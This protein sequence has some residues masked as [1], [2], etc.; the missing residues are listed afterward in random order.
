MDCKRS[1]CRRSS[2][3]IVGNDDLLMEIILRLPAKPL[4]RFKS[5][6]KHWHYLISAAF[7]SDR[8]TRLH[9]NRR[10]PQPSFIF[11]SVSRQF[12]YFNPNSKIFV[13][14]RFNYPYVRILQ[15]SHGL[16]LLECRNK[17]YGRKDYCVYNPVTRQ[18]R[19]LLIDSGDKTQPAKISALFLDFDPSKSL[20]YR[21]A[22]LRIIYNPLPEYSLDVYNSESHTWKR[23]LVPFTSH[24]NVTYWKGIYCN[25][26]VYW[27]RPGFISYYMDLQKGF[28]GTA[29]VIR[30]PSRKFLEVNKNYLMESNGHLHC[31][32]IYMRPQKKSLLV[33]ELLE[34]NSGW[35][36][37]YRVNLN[38]VSDA[39]PEMNSR[40]S[41]L[42]IVR[43]DRE[44]DSSVL[45]HVPG[46]VIL[47]WFF[48]ASFEVV[49][50]S[51]TDKIFRDCQFRF[52]RND[53]AYHFIE[54]LA[55]V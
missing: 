9:S 46:K 15:S 51:N 54:S 20:H 12:F 8:H 4:I 38:P 33:F 32:S 5:V 42:R 41:V 18:S 22:F 26:R 47:Y 19:K 55:S 14:F 29:P 39:L 53:D 49:L 34:D 13:P 27:I 11:H 37:R 48:Y 50:D 45:L 17:K 24:I 43:G 16:M 10:K 44:E 35:I 40:V 28:F 30:I 1:K 21:V 31:I 7:F 3:I 36:E 23:I 2:A 6:S 52:R 25:N